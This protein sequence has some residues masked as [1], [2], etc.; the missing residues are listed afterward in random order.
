M[1]VAIYPRGEVL[2][3][4]TKRIIEQVE[5]DGIKVLAAYREPLNGYWQF[6]IVAPIDKIQPAPFQRD[7]SETHCERLKMVIAK[8][9]RFIDPILVIRTEDG[10]YWTPNGH[11]RLVAMRELNASEITAVL[12]PDE[13][14]AS[15]IL[16]L[17]TEKVPDLRDKSLEVIRMYRNL[18]E[19]NP[20]LIEADFAPQF[21]SAHYIT[22]GI[23]YERKM[24]KGEKFSGTAYEPII[25]KVDMFFTEPLVTAI[26]KRKAMADRIEEL[27]NKVNEIIVELRNRG[28]KH[29]FIRQYVISL[30]NPIKRKRIVEESFDDVLDKLMENLNSLDLDAIRP[31]DI[32]RASYFGG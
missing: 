12:V 10:Q 27:H 6:F 21:D 18:M 15:Y 1:D 17:N 26:E 29:P 9:Q 23:V 7:I 19:K 24:E 20:D 2:D 8:T 22:F 16:A 13:K 3:E 25:K 14:V 28:V 11:H 31:E 4:E 5:A 30:V 32:E